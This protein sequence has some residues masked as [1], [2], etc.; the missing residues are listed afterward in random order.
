MHNEAHLLCNINRLLMKHV[1]VFVR[2]YS[3]G[4][5]CYN[6][7]KC[8]NITNKLNNIRT[9]CS[10]CFKYFNNNKANFEL[11]YWYKNENHYIVCL[12]CK[13]KN[14]QYNH[15]IHQLY[16]YFKLNTL[17]LMFETCAISKYMFKND[18]FDHTKH[19]VETIKIEKFDTLYNLLKKYKKCDEQVTRLV[20]RTYSNVVFDQN[21]CN[22]VYNM[23][24]KKWCRPNELSL[25]QMSVQLA[26]IVDK[27]N[28]S[29]FLIM[30]KCMFLN[31]VFDYMLQ[32]NVLKNKNFCK[33]CT[34]GKMHDTHA[35]M[36]CSTC[37]F[38]Q[39]GF[40][41]INNISYNNNCVQI[42]QWA[43]KAYIVYYKIA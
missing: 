36:Y 9:K 14:S 5:Y 32:I 11:Y 28:E 23:N 38:T 16:P 43:L 31:K 2:N 13:E 7:L 22:F 3:N 21:I 24:T 4:T 8:N 42:K 12:S 35:V 39:Y 17:K 1:H 33:R 15:N 30:H 34:S 27:K 19:N 37:G 6:Y 26:N 20:L 40:F 18:H 10:L 29:Y 41:S 25:M